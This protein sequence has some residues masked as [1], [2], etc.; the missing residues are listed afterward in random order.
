MKELHKQHHI[1]C[2]KH[3][4]I[5]NCCIEWFISTW[6]PAIG[7]NRD[8]VAVHHLNNGDVGYIRCPKCIENN[9]IVAIEKCDCV[10][11]ENKEDK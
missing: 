7:V 3:S 1:K 9:S 10:F 5:P 2:G 11:P 4:G 6:I 8:F